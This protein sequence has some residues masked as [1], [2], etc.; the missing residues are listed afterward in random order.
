MTIETPRLLLRPHRR[1]DLEHLLRYSVRPEY[2]RY[3]PVPPLTPEGVAALLERRIAAAARSDEMKSWVFAIEPQ[4]VGYT[5]GATR[6]SVVN[7]EHQVADI[8]FALDSDFYGRGYATEAARAVVSFGFSRLGLLRI[9]ATTDV[10]NEASCRVLER[11]GMK[12]EARLRHDKL[13]RGEW[14]DSFLYAILQPE[15]SSAA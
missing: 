14:R 10:E 5:V 8:G 11:L 3:L 1:D 13:M 7:Q 12:R 15:F 2:Y 6:I 4:Q 9:W